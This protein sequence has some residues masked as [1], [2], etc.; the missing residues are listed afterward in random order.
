MKTKLVG[1]TGQLLDL[2]S[3]TLPQ[4][5][6]V[7]LM[8]SGHYGIGKSTLALSLAEN[9]CGDK[10]GITHVIGR[11]V[12][13]HWVNRILEELGTSS[14]Y[15]SGW[16]ALVIDEIDTAQRDAIDGL[17]YLL[18]TLPVHR[19]VIGTTNLPFGEL[20][21]RFRSRFTRYE[22]RAPDEAE[23][24]ALLEEQEELPEKVAAHIAALSG[25]NVRGALRDAEAWRNENST[26][27]AS[28]PRPLQT[29]LAAL[30]F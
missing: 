3:V 29:S 26:P 18:D 8:F 2:L 12:T 5:E 11:N 30:G 21:E 28:S 25:G 13:I 15:G 20:P 4:K 22:V 23:I 24:A 17:L 16:K 7:A 9:L 10:W 6:R 14:L 1:H 27:V 19:A